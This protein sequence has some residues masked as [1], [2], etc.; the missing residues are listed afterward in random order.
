MG[1]YD[2]EIMSVERSDGTLVVSFREKSPQP[3]AVLTQPFHIVCIEINE[4]PA[5]RFRRAP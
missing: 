3:G 5:V 1:G 2:V 4:T